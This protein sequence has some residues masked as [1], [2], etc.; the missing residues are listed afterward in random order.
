MGKKHS[1]EFRKVLHFLICLHFKHSGGYTKTGIQGIFLL[2]LKVSILWA[3]P[4]L[5]LILWTAFRSEAASV[6]Q[7]ENIKTTMPQGKAF[8]VR[9]QRSINRERHKELLQRSCYG[10]FFPMRKKSLVFLS[11]SFIS[12]TMYSSTFQCLRVI[13]RTSLQDVC[14]FFQHR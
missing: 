12:F 2:A 1:P 6:Y 10:N 5:F 9:L 7:T 11:F 3:L 14:S 13:L 8:C 4:E